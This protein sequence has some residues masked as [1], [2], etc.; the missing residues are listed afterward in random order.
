[1][2][3]Y[4]LVNYVSSINKNKII[5]DTF[6]EEL[7]IYPYKIVED[8]ICKDSIRSRQTKLDMIE[9]SYKNAYNN[10][11]WTVNK[12]FDDGILKELYI[13]VGSDY[14]EDITVSYREDI[15]ELADCIDKSDYKLRTMDFVYDGKIYNGISLNDLSYIEKTENSNIKNNIKNNINAFI[16]GLMVCSVVTVL[17]FIRFKR[18]LIFGFVNLSIFVISFY[19][20][21]G[22]G[23]DYLESILNEPTSKIVE[24]CNR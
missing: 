10:G 22:S 24:V 7:E 17:T 19:M 11:S 16:I 12:R 23:V 6:D 21:I 5:I 14:N 1:M 9:N 2:E 4:H 15:K 18:S 13:P 8:G 3:K 20:L